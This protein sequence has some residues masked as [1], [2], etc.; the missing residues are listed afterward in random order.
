ML[1]KSN[2]YLVQ[3]C[4]F[5]SLFVCLGDQNFLQVPDADV[6]CVCLPRY[7][8][9]DVCKVLGRDSMRR[10]SAKPQMVFSGH[11]GRFQTVRLDKKVTMFGAEILRAGTPLC[12][13]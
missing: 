5:R 8:M 9:L 12:G 2:G 4:I 6:G 10:K 1:K 13:Q 11:I 3:A 7:L